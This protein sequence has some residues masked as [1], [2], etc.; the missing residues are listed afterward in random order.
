VGARRHPSSYRAETRSSAIVPESTEQVRADFDR[1]AR[2]MEAAG[3]GP[4]QPYLHHLPSSVPPDCGNALEV[5]CGTGELTRLLADRCGRVLAIDLSPEMIRIA[6]RNSAALSNVEYR[7]A[8]VMEMALP[9]EA[10]D[11]VAS[12]ATLHHLPA[13]DAV[14]RMQAALRPGGVL[15]L[16]DVLEWSGPTGFLVS[17]VATL[18]RYV[19]AHVRGPRRTSRA[20]REAWRAHGA[21]ERY[22]RPREV[23]DLVR[24]EL[25]GAAVRL[26]LFW[27]YTVVWTK[28][29]DGSARA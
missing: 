14:R 23:R 28:P 2:E 19:R 3:A 24:R 8:D 22:L 7:V 17:A 13:A 10:F 21:G 15:I 16:H 26:H 6:R 5:G 18:A 25:P 29:R 9:D 11:C 12:V 27:R 1:I 20:L 4:D